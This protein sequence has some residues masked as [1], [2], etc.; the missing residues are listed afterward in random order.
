MRKVNLSCHGKSAQ[1]RRRCSLV[2]WGGSAPFTHF[3]V[4]RAVLSVFFTLFFL[5]QFLSH[6]FCP[7][8]FTL[9][10]PA[11]HD[12]VI[13]DRQLALSAVAKTE[14]ALRVF[15]Q[16]ALIQLRPW[17]GG[18]RFH[19]S[20]AQTA[21]ALRTIY[22]DVG[23]CAESNDIS[24]KLRISIFSFRCWETPVFVHER[25][26]CTS[27]TFSLFSSLVARC[28]ACRHPV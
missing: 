16:I 13:V 9:R 8:V 10:T 21:P 5:P 27:I 12:M 1:Y 4:E 19:K 15:A 3:G 26:Q 18:V 14:S 24:H 2:V 20:H 11:L 25:P 17:K 22:T 7:W 23:V 28:Y 6:K